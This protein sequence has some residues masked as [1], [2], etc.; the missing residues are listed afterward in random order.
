[1]KVLITRSRTMNQNTEFALD[2]KG[3]TGIGCSLVEMIDT[4]NEIPKV[5]YGGVIFT[6]QAA[7]EILE[8]REKNGQMISRTLNVYAVGEKT[9]ELARKLGFTNVFISNGGA[10][11]LNDLIDET[12]FEKPLLYL[13]GVNRAY[14]F[15]TIDTV[16]V[17]IYEARLSDPGKE[18]LQW[19]LNQVSG[20]CA[21]LYSVRTATHLLDLISHHNLEK[22]IEN[23]TFIAISKMVAEAIAS[24]I[25]L[26]VQTATDPSQAQ[27][28]ELLGKIEKSRT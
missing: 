4:G 7:L 10:Q 15:L 28:I 18:F 3:Y 26:P 21:F 17:E 14:N 1:M 9:G 6:S 16:L 20:G 8:E 13:A 22:Y 25:K 19:A 27:M 24:K 11:A 23:V 2:A 12:K 5:G